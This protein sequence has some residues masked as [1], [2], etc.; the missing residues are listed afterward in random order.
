MKKSSLPIC[1]LYVCLSA[2]THNY[3][4]KGITS[5][6][7]NGQYVRLLEYGNFIE[8]YGN[9][10]VD[11][12]LVCNQ[13]F[14]FKGTA[15]E[16]ALYFINTKDNSIDV[17]VEPGRVRLDMTQSLNLGGTRL[18]DALIEYNKRMETFYADYTATDEQNEEKLRIAEEYI[19]SYKGS[20][21]ADVVLY[22]Y[23][24]TSRIEIEE[25]DHLYSLMDNRTPKFAVLTGAIHRIEALRRTSE[26][27]MF[28]DFT[29]KQGNMDGTDAKLSDYVGKGKYVLIDFWASWCGW[30]R[31]EFPVLS[32]VYQ[33]HKDDNFQMVGV[34]VNDKMEN[35]MKALEVE[36]MVVWPQIVNAGKEVMMTYGIGGIPEIILFAPDGTIL[37]RGLR[38]E[39]LKN[40]VDEVFASSK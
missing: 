7:M 12:A 33:K 17:I 22:N 31:K 16:D 1:V 39:Q 8:G 19:K 18:N 15:K 3:S 11:S 23:I 28:T 35:T 10:C 34:V 6:E 9:Q 4:I 40:K 13:S 21:L 38:G 25:F 36:T 24:S 26:G 29:V 32:E 2:C 20:V 37:A 5:P 14:E 30:C 27:K